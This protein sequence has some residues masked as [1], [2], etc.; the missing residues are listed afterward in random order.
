MKNAMRGKYDN[1]DGELIQ[2]IDDVHRQVGAAQRQMFRLIAEVDRREAWRGCGAR[3]LARWLSMRY[4]ISAWKAHRWITAAHA[5]EDPPR[6]AEAFS[7]GELGWTRW[8]S[9]PG[10]P[11]RRPKEG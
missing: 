11:P 3:D 7:S 8:W 1:T 9:S 4:G 10:S 6:L 2:A 5:L